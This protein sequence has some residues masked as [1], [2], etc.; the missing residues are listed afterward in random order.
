MIRAVLFDFDGVL[1]DSFSFHF[2]AWQQVI[3]DFDVR[4]HGMV[5]KLYEGQPARYMAQA[6][7]NAAGLS[8]DRETANILA[9]Q[10]NAAFRRLGRAPIFP[11]AFELL[12]M[13]KQKALKTAVVTGTRIDNVRHVLGDTRLQS[14][15]AII[16]DGD[17]RHPKPHAEPYLLAAERLALAPQNCLVVENAP[18][19]VAAA[20]QA[21]MFCIALMTTLTEEHLTQA[22]VIVKDHY[23]LVDRFDLLLRYQG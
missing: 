19:G 2:R 5:I 6:I 9:G 14:F 10:K 22:D 7:Y 13:A 18:L 8:L 20:K 16:Q 23:A 4:P 1:A 3:T 21:G 11:G 15:D 12:Q 17:Y